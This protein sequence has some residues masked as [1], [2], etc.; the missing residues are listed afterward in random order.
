MIV[1]ANVVFGSL[2]VLTL[3]MEAIYSPKLQ[4]SQEGHVITSQKTT[5]FVVTAMKALNLT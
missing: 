4:F 3:M 1:T 5:F 2:I